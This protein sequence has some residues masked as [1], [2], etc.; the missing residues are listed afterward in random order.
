ML[1][2]ML[3]QLSQASAGLTLALPADGLWAVLLTLDAS[4]EAAAA[5]CPRLQLLQ[6]VAVD[7]SPPEL[8]WVQL[9]APNDAALLES[10]ACAL[11]QGTKQHSSDPAAAISSASTGGSTSGISTGISTGTTSAASSDA[12]QLPAACH[13]VLQLHW[14]KPIKKLLPTMIGY[15]RCSLA[16][17]SCNGSQDCVM[18]VAGG[19]GQ[20]GSRSGPTTDCN[21]AVR[22]LTCRRTTSQSVHHSATQ[23][24]L[25]PAG[26]YV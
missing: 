4:K 15:R 23:R 18:T 5:G 25:Q 17:L 26:I 12:A 1:G 14:S 11:H 13:F 10:A 9:A 24:G 7:T 21:A 22:G 3:L 16:S 8:T 2:V 6:L 19:S 20:L